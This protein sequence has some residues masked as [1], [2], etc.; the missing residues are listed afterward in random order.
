MAHSRQFILCYFIKDWI[1]ELAWDE[2]TKCLAAC[3]YD[4]WLTVNCR[5]C[6]LEWA[7]YLDELVFLSTRFGQWTATNRF[8][9]Q[10]SMAHVGDWLGVQTGNKRTAR[11]CWT[12]P[13]NRPTI[14]FWLGELLSTD[15]STSLKNGIELRVLHPLFLFAP[16]RN[17]LI[18]KK[19]G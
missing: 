15:G 8:T 1:K 12:R 18:L 5:C 19:N 3:S 17:S 13:G 14:S 7:C 11:E 16:K 9:T 10:R 6:C 2:R 4:G